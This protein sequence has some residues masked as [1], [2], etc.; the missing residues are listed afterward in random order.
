MC[1]CSVTQW[2]PA[3]CDLMDCSTP[4]FPVLHFL[5]D[6]AQTYVHW[7]GNVIQPYHPL[8][9]PSPPA[10]SLSHIS[11]EVSWVSESTFRIRWPK[12]WSLSFSPSNECSG[13]IS[14]RIDWFD[15]LVVQGTLKNLL[16]HQSLKASILWH[17]AFFM[18]QVSH[19]YMTTAKTRAWTVWFLG[20][21]WWLR[22]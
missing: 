13:L 20:R 14:F 12:D 6:F 22:Q 8:S 3:L 7:V 4:G 21:P 5:L 17:S 19:L 15:L 16:Q 10:L 2:G 1:C 9:P 18:V 11:H